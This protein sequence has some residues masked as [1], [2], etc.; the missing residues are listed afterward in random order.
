MI[1]VTFTIQ[2]MIAMLKR[3]WKA[4]ASKPESS[5]LSCDNTRALSLPK[6]TTMLKRFLFAVLLFVAAGRAAAVDYTDIWYIPTESGW[7]VNVVQS[8]AFIFMTFFIYGPDNKPTWY[9]ANVTQDSSGNFNGPL[10]STT[11][12]SFTL[13]WVPSQ[14]G[15]AQVGTASFQPTGPSTARLV[16]TLTSG[17][18]LVPVTKMIQRQ[19]LTAITLGSAHPYS[20]AQFS[21]FTGCANNGSYRDFF[22]LQL[23]QFTDGTVTFA[24]LYPEYTNYSC[25]FSGTLVQLGQLYSVT[26]ATYQCTDGRNTTASMTEI[27]ATAQGVEARFSASYGGSCREDAR[28]SGVLN[29]LL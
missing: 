29:S 7:G 18:I 13:P 15:G 17:P 1:V 9:V 22:D 24:F 2:R 12:T 26:G 20:G 3:L 14:Y 28:F 16:Y 25:T 19:T 10:Y 23:T 8:D 4:V 6:A 21:T 27:K 5:T 11:G